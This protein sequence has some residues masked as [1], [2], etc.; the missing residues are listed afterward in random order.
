M[1][2]IPK[3]SVNSYVHKK[4]GYKYPG[5]VMSV[6]RNRKGELRYVVEAI[7]PDFEGM[8]HIFNED[9]LVSTNEELLRMIITE[10]HTRDDHDD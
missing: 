2:T 1:S 3:F 4:T 9:Q 10:Y 6:F 5:Q 7:H 8:L